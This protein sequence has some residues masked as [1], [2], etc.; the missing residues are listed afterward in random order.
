MLHTVI[1]EKPTEEKWKYKEL[2]QR[3][4]NQK[5]QYPQRDI[6]RINL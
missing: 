3:S 6:D 4:K 2:T 5:L 1:C